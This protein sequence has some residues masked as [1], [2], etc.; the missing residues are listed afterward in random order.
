MSKAGPPSEV[1]QE[2]VVAALP[3]EVIIVQGGWEESEAITSAVEGD[4]STAA[5]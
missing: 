5:S 4:R 2:F 1:V 3:V